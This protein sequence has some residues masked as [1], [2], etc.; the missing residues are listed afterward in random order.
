MKKGR[1]VFCNLFQLAH[2]AFQLK[3]KFITAGNKL[4]TKNPPHSPLLLNSVLPWLISTT[5]SNPQKIRA[6]TTPKAE[7]NPQK[8][9]YF[10]F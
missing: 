10:S 3:N 1:P 5:G 8:S 7:E 4:E 9:S 2:L 6:K